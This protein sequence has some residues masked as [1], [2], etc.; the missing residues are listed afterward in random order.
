[1]RF[2]VEQPYNITTPFS[3]AHLGIDIAPVPAGSTGR[4]VLSPEPSVVYQLGN[5]PALEGKYIILKGDS[6]VYYYFG[7]FA[8]LFVFKG[9]RLDEGQP[10]GV[11]GMTGLATGIHTHHE[12]RPNQPGPG[13][14]IDPAAYYKSKGDNMDDVYKALDATNKRVDA[15][16]TSVN[17]LYN[18]VDQMQKNLDALQKQ[19]DGMTSSVDLTKL[20]IVNGG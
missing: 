15:L 10:I 19:V 12:V 11:M 14:Q 8:E 2:P 5:N 13:T 18:I 6:G 9:Q 4:Q 7:H 1:V 17:N 20:R 16:E 3:A